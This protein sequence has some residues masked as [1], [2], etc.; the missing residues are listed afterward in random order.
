M[1]Q[2]TYAYVFRA[3][4]GA[5]VPMLSRGVEFLGSYSLLSTVWEFYQYMSLVQYLEIYGSPWCNFMA[6]EKAE[7]ELLF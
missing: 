4:C 7:Y 3:F 5:R 1:H 2:F 6:G